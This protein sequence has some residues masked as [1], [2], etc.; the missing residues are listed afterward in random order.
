MSITPETVEHVAKLARLAITPDEAQR[1]SKDL[2]NIMTLVAQLEAL[3]LSAIEL[4]PETPQANI[5]R[6][7]VAVREFE[8]DALLANAPDREERFFRVPRI[9]D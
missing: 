9:L 6:P 2:S 7:D 4:D 8:P 5:L 1:Y 3:D